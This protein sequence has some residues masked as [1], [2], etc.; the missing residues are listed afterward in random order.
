MK[1]RKTESMKISELR[2]DGGPL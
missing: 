1:R 2:R